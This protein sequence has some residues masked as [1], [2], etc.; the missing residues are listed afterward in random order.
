MERS[1]DRGRHGPPVPSGR[2]CKTGAASVEMGHGPAKSR[3]DLLLVV[4]PEGA[5]DVEKVA[6]PGLTVR[7]EALAGDDVDVLRARDH[8]QQDVL[9][10]LRVVALH[11]EFLNLAGDVADRLG[12][13]FALG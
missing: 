13:L 3:P 8:G 12:E 4:E 5:D 1:R 2:G 7:P 6:A 10:K 9:L 11:F